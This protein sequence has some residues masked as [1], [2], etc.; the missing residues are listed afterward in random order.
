MIKVCL[1]R[2]GQ[3]KIKNHAEQKIENWQIKKSI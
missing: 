2:I 3:K 1:K